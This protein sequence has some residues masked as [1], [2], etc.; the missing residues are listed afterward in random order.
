MINRLKT[1]RK[2]GKQDLNL[3]KTTARSPATSK[4]PLA[5]F[6]R[7]QHTPTTERY[8]RLNSKSPLQTRYRQFFTTEIQSSQIDQPESLLT[9]IK[10]R[11][12]HKNPQKPSHQLAQ[13]VLKL[14]FLP[15]FK[16]QQKLDTDKRRII[17]YGNSQKPRVPQCFKP[18]SEMLQELLNKKKSELA[19]IQS[20]LE[21]V[22]QDKLKMKIQLSSLKT[23]K[24]TLNINL[25][26]IFSDR[27]STFVPTQSLISV[28][29]ACQSEKI[30]FF[31]AFTENITLKRTLA[32][33]KWNNEDL[34]SE[35]VQLNFYNCEY[36][37][38]N[39]ISGESLKGA[40]YSL[41]ALKNPATT[42]NFLYLI[43]VSL[44]NSHRVFLDKNESSFVI[45]SALFA[46]HEKYLKLSK[47]KIK[48]RTSAWKDL[49]S[50]KTTVST[51]L[52]S[53]LSTL[54]TSQTQKKKI[55]EEF[56][57]KEKDFFKFIEDYKNIQ[58]KVEE[59]QKASRGKRAELMCKYC[60]QEFFEDE[61]FNW[62]CCS[63]P[64]E[65]GGTMY[66][67]CGAK[68]KSRIGCFKRKHEEEN[69]EEEEENLQVLEY[70]KEKLI[71]KFCSGCKKPGHYS[72]ECEKD[73]NRVKVVKSSIM[74]AAKR[75]KKVFEINRSL[76]S[77]NLWVKVKL[78][79]GN[80]SF[81]DIKEI[82]RLASRNVTP[83]QSLNTQNS[84]RSVFSSPLR[85]LASIRK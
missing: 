1:Q 31:K 19:S 12:T 61:N 78:K 38:I 28:S 76:S 59:A 67:C 2:F 16:E 49:K 42:E 79:K 21:Y 77:R 41:S 27:F 34:K 70:N 13:S 33:E 47:S 39:Q 30:E 52:D 51:Y 35:S 84:A 3:Q 71:V 20:K 82:K 75:K 11:K 4:S 48:Q 22:E 73:P 14:Y 18:L 65:W 7:R 81:E 80:E 29:S 45:F 36:Y 10:S 17:S 43:Q 40:Y 55:F 32:K 58:N 63:H 9:Q 64:S 23:S 83:E 5:T 44:K 56:E 60:K 66:W 6:T 15:F 46:D 74:E 69:N 53:I 50:L 68:E 25:N 37:L 57:I 54:K 26:A 8:F 24:F 85:S 62:S 72:S